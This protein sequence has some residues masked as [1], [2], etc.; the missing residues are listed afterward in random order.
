[1]SD[2]LRPCG[3]RP[4]R[5]LC[6]WDFSGKNTRVGSHFLLQEI[7]STQ[8]SNLCLLTS[9]L[10]VGS[11][12]LV[13][14]GKPNL[15]T[16]LIWKTAFTITY[17]FTAFSPQNNSFL[18]K[19]Y[20]NP[21]LNGVEDNGNWYHANLFRA[22]LIAQLVKNPLAMQTWVRS[23]GWEIPGEGKGYP[24]QYW[25]SLIAQL[26]K[27]PPAMEETLV[28]FLGWEDPLERG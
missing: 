13:P 7:F 10:V 2:S 12:Q 21:Q 22:S 4:A 18:Q 27:N 24:L 28:W 11:L 23:L 16:V 25:A 1:M 26:L 17:V 14:H 5:L 6:P 3:Q 19:I 20:L 15:Y 8:D 9:E